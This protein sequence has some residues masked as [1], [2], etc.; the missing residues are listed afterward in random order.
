LTAPIRVAVVGYG[1]A[2]KTFHAPL[3]ASVP[4]LELRAV[5]SSDP[6]KVAAD[7][8]GLAVEATAEALFARDDIDLVVVP[9]PNETHH[10]LARAALQAG[11]HVVVD[12]PFTLDLAQARELDALAT[13]R[14]RLLSVFHNRRWDGD[15]LTVRELIASGRLGRIT[16]FESRVDRFRPRVRQRWRE[17]DGPGS[18]VW[19]DHGP[20]LLD[21]ALLLFGEPQAISLERMAQRDGAVTDDAFHARLRYASGPCVVLQASS[22]AAAAGPRLTVHGTRGSFVK[23]GADPQEDALKAGQRPA[24][25]T[26]PPEVAT[27]ALQDAQSPDAVQ[28]SSHPV[29]AG[30]HVA[31][32][33]GVRDAVLGQAP[34]PVPASEAAQ[35]MAWL[36]LGAASDAARREL[37]PAA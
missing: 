9:T 24:T 32:Y 17:A 6:A 29:R 5:S 15:F 19:M 10:P 37:S 16:H 34:N 8:R 12:K 11:K 1:Y 28:V 22:L 18:G 36:E 20:H 25:W 31:Y 14:G 30:S 35:V 7:W 13:Q 27:L 2:T 26:L 4:G 33:E 21:Q 23:W 3:I